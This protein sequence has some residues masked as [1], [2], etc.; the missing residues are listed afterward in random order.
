MISER[1]EI[2]SG[3]QPCGY[4]VLRAEAMPKD[5]NSN[6]DIFGGWILAQMDIAGWMMSR[7]ITNGRT[8][9]VTLD[10]MVF[11]LPVHTGDIVSIYAELV[12]VG[13]SSLDLRL[14]V[15][16]K[17][18]SGEFVAE[19]HLVTEGIFRY[20]AIDKQGKPRKVPDNPLFFSRSDTT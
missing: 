15:W 2:Q 16:A 19:R 18:I 13:N 12:R 4:L 1:K 17:Q 20:V 11:K 6:G 8:V 5:T 3:R 14:E 7:E 10:K 9:T